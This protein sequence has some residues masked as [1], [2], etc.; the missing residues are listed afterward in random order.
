M[1]PSGRGGEGGER[2][3]RRTKEERARKN[4][5]WGLLTNDLGDKGGEENESNRH[6]SSSQNQLINHIIE[7]VQC[8]L[9]C[10][11]CGD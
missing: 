8:V 6:V 11:G 3:G 9:V 5:E 2:D 1:G 7:P 10:V 4:L